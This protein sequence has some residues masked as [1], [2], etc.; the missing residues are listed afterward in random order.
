ML[1]EKG[2]KSN[3]S[4]VESESSIREAISLRLMT[5]GDHAFLQHLFA[6]TRDDEMAMV[7]HWNAE[8]KQEFLH[9]QWS[10]QLGHYQRHYPGARHE[11]LLDKRSGR[12]IGRLYV[13]RDIDQ[14]RLMDIALLPEYRN[15]GIGSALTRDL[16]DEARAN[17]QFVGL[18]VWNGNRGAYRFYSRLGFEE[19]GVE[20]E[21]HIKMEWHG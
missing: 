13:D 7:P 9:S 6:T 4:A 12:P 1:C 16:I 17:N 10:A 8:Q 2:N 3:L 20:S 11:I 21:M 5:S 15:R 19:R 18:Y 14:I